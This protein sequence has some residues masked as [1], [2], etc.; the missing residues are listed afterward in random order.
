MFGREWSVTLGGDAEL[1][2]YSYIDGYTGSFEICSNR[3]GCFS[4]QIPKHRGL[5]KM[6]INEG[7]NYN[8][9]YT[10]RLRD[11]SSHFFLFIFSHPNP[12]DSFSY[13]RIVYRTGSVVTSDFLWERAF[14]YRFVIA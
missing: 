8:D 3:T 11:L 14:G 7:V 9:V 4:T 5:E 12:S 1:S 2:L 6:L 10:I 13:F